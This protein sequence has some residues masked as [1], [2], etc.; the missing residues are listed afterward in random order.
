MVD[1]KVVAVKDACIGVVGGGTPLWDH[2]KHLKT[3][4][5]KGKSCS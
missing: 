5:G 1:G 4:V 3:G 2:E